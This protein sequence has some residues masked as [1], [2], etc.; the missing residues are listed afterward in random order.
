ME[1][2]FVGVLG[3][4]RYKVKVIHKVLTKLFIKCLFNRFLFWHACGVHNNPECDI[5]RL[6]FE[7]AGP[8]DTFDHWD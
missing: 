1:E 3:I 2:I 4:I 5:D 8:K 6:V 7:L